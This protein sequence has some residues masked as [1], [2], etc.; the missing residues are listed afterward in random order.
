VIPLRPYQQDLV[1]R[2]DDEWRH[3]ARNVLMR[4]GTGG[5]KCLARGTPVL[6]YDGSIR[7]VESIRRGE[8]LMGPDSTPRVV[9]S[10]CS[11]RENMYRVVPVKG[12]PYTVNES[13]ILSLQRTPQA[14]A[15]RYPSLR[16]GGEIVD[17]SVREYLTKGATWKHIHKGYRVGVDFPEKAYDPA[18]PPYFLGVWLGDGTS[19]QTSVT[20]A[21]FEIVEYLHQHAEA[22]GLTLTT[23]VSAHRTPVYFL[24]SGKASKGLKWRR[25]PVRQALSDHGLLG[26]KHIPLE[27]KT[28][29]R[30]QRLELLAGLMDTDGSMTRT[31]YDY[32]SVSRT[33]AEDVAYVARSLG[34]AAYVQMCTKSCN[35]QPEALYH[36]VSISGNCDEI[37]VRIAR[38]K[39]PARGQIKS[40]LRTG[41]RI[42][43]KGEGEYFGFEIDGDRRFLLG[44][45]TVTHNTVCFGS[46]IAR[47]V[48]AS[49]LLVHRTELVTQI[50]LTLARLG[51][52][53][54]VLAADTTR[55]AV[56]RAHVEELGA[57]YYQPG[58]RCAVASV[59]TLARAKGLESWAAQ[60]TLW[61][62][63]EGHHALVENKWGRA[64][65]LFTHPQCRGLL[66]TA[67]P[68]RADGKGL[69]SHADGF[70]DVM[71]EGPPERWL[72]DQGYLTDYR[73]VCPTSDIV[74]YV[75]DAGASGDYS[76]AQMRTAAQRSHITGDLPREYSRWTPGLLGIS[77]CTDVDT[78][79]ETTEA[80]RAL[81]VTAETLTG[82][83]ADHVRRDML[84]RFARREILELCVVDIVSEGFDLPA[85]QVGSFG[86]PSESLGLVRQ[87]IGRVLRPMYAPGPDL[88]TQAG[89]LEAIAA[90]DKPY[91]WLID[92][93]Q[94]IT[95]PHI[96]PP[97]RP[98]IWSLDRRDKKAST[99][100]TDA[101]PLRVCAAPT[102]LR[103]Y[104]RFYKAC[105]FCG[106]EPP[107]AGRSSPA[108]VEGDLAELD[109][110]VLAALRGAVEQVDQSVQ[111]MAAAMSDKRAQPIW[112][113]RHAKFHMERQA[114]QAMLRG[115]MAR[116]DAVPLPP[117]CGQSEADRLFYLRYGIDRLSAQALGTNDAWALAER[118]DGTISY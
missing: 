32:I 15:G 112:I 22:C 21:D 83:T 92:H 97:D 118:I 113:Q 4:L 41:I 7:P 28:G 114:G 46:I 79:V 103:P 5:G 62:C 67:T 90:S 82:N 66:P 52:R 12:D 111:E 87:Q 25:N 89:R 117:G 110:A 71:I 65:S 14:K 50:S 54:D 26:N 58:A 72:I 100:A 33:L 2:V 73:V 39:A 98:R 47:H 30:Q 69:G 88:S 20:S 16:R 94:H 49:C 60:V 37:P 36:R 75:G 59:D 13:H 35:G 34:F 9:L 76:P 45:F 64:I 93:V 109:P 23:N 43:P 99:A 17:I 70:A 63:D 84:R 11:G 24:S 81:G 78:A 91:A 86:R 68:V 48:G 8:L 3:G 19:L 10:T 38:K 106:H 40:V 42:E 31:N 115:A 53:H 74:A 105:P 61:I 18:L 6:M 55:R 57:C 96:G 77:F 107:L 29:S 27:Y 56:A 44:D 80:Y 51:I 102:C 85:C 116:W 1:D 101:I 104:E 108:Q 95:K